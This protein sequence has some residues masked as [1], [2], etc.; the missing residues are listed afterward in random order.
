MSKTVEKKKKSDKQY[1]RIQLLE[2]QL[3]TFQGRVSYLEAKVQSLTEI[4]E[5]TLQT[6][7]MT[8]KLLTGKKNR[9][10]VNHN[11]VEGGDK[12]MKGE[13]PGVGVEG[14]NIDKDQGVKV[15][16]KGDEEKGKEAKEVGADEGI[17]KVESKGEKKDGQKKQR[18][19]FAWVLVGVQV[20]IVVIGAVLA[21]WRNFDLYTF[22][23]FSLYGLIV[24]IIAAILLPKDVSQRP[25][26][27]SICMGFFFYYFRINRKS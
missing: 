6:T 5:K 8:E 7:K 13:Q 16:G 15:E 3:E 27:I 14:I 9:D 12:E 4:L 18:E 23:F 24:L 26:R 22:V 1:D 20:L 11:A 19:T 17:V 25:L 21:Y 10:E 2:E